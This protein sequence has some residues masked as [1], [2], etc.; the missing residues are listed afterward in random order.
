[1][2][3]KKTPAKMVYGIPAFDPPD[4]LEEIVLQLRAL[5]PDPILVVDDGSSRA[6]ASRFSA[7]ADMP[8]VTVLRHPANLGKGAALKTA[9]AYAVENFPGAIGMVTLDADGQH[10]PADA[11][12]VAA[13]LTKAPES[14]VLGVRDLANRGTVPF[15]SKWGNAL[16]RAVFKAFTGAVVSD[17]Q[18]GL[19][20]IPRALMMSTFV[21]SL[22]GY[23]FEMDMLLR[24]LQQGVEVREVGIRTI[25]LDGNRTSH[26]DPLLDSALIYFVFLRHTLVSI[27]SAIV[28]TVVFYA[29]SRTAVSIFAG[30]IIGRLI[31]ATFNFFIAKTVVFQSRRATKPEFLRYLL[32]GG[33]LLLISY[34]SV[35]FLTKRFGV[36]LIFAKVF[37]ESLLFFPGFIVQRRLVFP[38]PRARARVVRA[39]EKVDQEPDRANVRVL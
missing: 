5:T 34:L 24:A 37:T 33:S 2:S 7:I 16:T 18:T 28:D 26:F 19:R 6:H 11:V 39:F 35:S 10:L 31:G 36:N 15:R 22:M 30:S 29:V 21:S 12:K 14:L 23:D 9:F 1:M 20:G 17:T 8:G 32:L 27:M 3:G 4:R 38:Q 13:E 25:Y